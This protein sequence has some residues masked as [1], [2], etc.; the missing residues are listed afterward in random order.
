MEM[1]CAAAEQVPLLPSDMVLALSNRDPRSAAL[2]ALFGQPCVECGAAMG[3]MST[4]FIDCAVCMGKCAACRP[5]PCTNCYDDDDFCGRGC[6]SCLVYADCCNAGP[7]CA[8]CAGD[9]TDCDGP[10]G[11]YTGCNR[12]RCEDCAVSRLCP[13]SGGFEPPARRPPAPRP[14]QSCHCAPLARPNLSTGKLVVRIATHLEQKMAGQGYIIPCE[15]AILPVLQSATTHPQLLEVLDAYCQGHIDGL[16]GAYS[17][18]A[19]GIRPIFAEVQEQVRAFERSEA[20]ST[21]CE[22]VR[23]GL[24]ELGVLGDDPMRGGQFVMI[25]SEFMRKVYAAAIA[26]QLLTRPCGAAADGR[27]GAVASTPPPPPTAE[28]L[29]C[30]AADGDLPAVDTILAALESVASAGAPGGM[31]ASARAVVVRTLRTHRGV[32]CKTQRWIYFSEAVEAANQAA[33]S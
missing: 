6:E 13:C 1:D 21:A 22:R 8:G 33:V 29:L 27:G 14:A 15:A 12:R 30:L 26:T 20:Y 11:D 32:A 28:L 18:A 5:L 4:C 23:S 24:R 25:L 19:A 9:L 3:D 7:M 16:H 31:S 2:K 17:S 10:N